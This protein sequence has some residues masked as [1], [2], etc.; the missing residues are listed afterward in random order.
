[1]P[2]SS[3]Q[4]SRGSHKSVSTSSEEEQQ[5]NRRTVLKLDLLLLP[6]LSLLFLLN[7][8]DRSNIGNAETANF[9]QDAGLQPKD[10]NTAV[11]FF[12]AFFVALQPIGAA[13]GR[14][15]GMKRWVPGC[16]AIWGICTAL[17]IW[18]RR[19]WQLITIRVLIGILEAGFYPTTVSYL[20]LF[21]T[22][23]E[24]ARRL[25]FFYGQVAVAGALGGLLSY[26]VFSAFPPDELPV[27]ADISANDHLSSAST[28]SAWKP[29][30][31][32]FLIEGSA[33]CVVAL[34]GFLWLPRDAASAWFLGEVERK[35][36]EERI[37]RD[38]DA[39][40]IGK[41]S[42]AD[43]SLEETH[44][45]AAQLDHTNDDDSQTE[46]LL[47]ITSSQPSDLGRRHSHISIGS[48]ITSDRGLT[49]TDI[50]SAIT[51]WK[52]WY[53]LVVNICSSIPAMAFSV[54]CPLVVKGLG[55]DS[56]RA[57]LLTAPP[58]AIGALVLWM[59][60]WWSDHRKE[61]ILPILCGL[62]VMLV[63]LTAT[64]ML[65]EEA[66]GA[67]YGALCVLLGGSFIASPLTVA[68]L[69]GNIEEP[70]K[71]AIVLGINGW[72]TLAGL[73]SAE[74]F[75]PKY[76]P[77]YITPFYVTLCLVL[78]SFLGYALFRTL[79]VRENMSRA[80]IR[81]GWTLEELEEELEWGTG[82]LPWNSLRWMSRISHAG[83]LGSLF[84]RLVPFQT[85][86]DGEPVRRRGD[87]KITFVY[88]L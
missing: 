71:R 6:F 82:P 55:F 19:R 35:W 48:G 36:A 9:T 39:V 88:G 40:Q 44:D 83:S 32:L 29:W 16:M 42:T 26:G 65:P 66:Y 70:G 62:G 61:R 68:W 56:I 76:A 22:R 81:Q 74:L 49:R 41:S 5:L 59:F 67:R 12:F 18:I 64:V 84:S 73:F 27:A 75:S 24:F 11:A 20:S 14:R 13:A 21:Y 7:S 60:T 53:L 2:S 45:Q 37:L 47:R 33:T 58:F 23:F 85:T 25:G 4:R 28:T 69:A 79:L 51:E 38:R 30:Q 54:F 77:H 3:R 72:G 15:W 8:L 46:H 86:T 52:I 57:N 1:M 78:T 63:G 34:W 10:L 87:E 50:V 17:H 31:V 43:K 80:R